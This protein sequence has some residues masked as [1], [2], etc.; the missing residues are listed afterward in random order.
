MADLQTAITEI[1]TAVAKAILVRT[2]EKK[3][4]KDTAVKSADLDHKTKSKVQKESDLADTESDLKGTQSEMD[5]ALV[6]YEKL[7]PSCQD[8]TV[9]YDD[10]VSQREEEI[11]SL[12]EAL[13][14]LSN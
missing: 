5:A 12:K 7:K 13:Q 9:T 6:Y 3:K 10:R 4:N 2:A 14:I 8:A 11:A 1:D